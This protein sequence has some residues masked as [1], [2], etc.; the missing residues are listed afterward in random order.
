MFCTTDAE[1]ENALE[2]QRSE[3][4]AWADAAT[5]LVDCIARY[6]ARHPT[7]SIMMEHTCRDRSDKLRLSAPLSPSST[8]PASVRKRFKA[9]N[10]HD[11]LR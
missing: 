8:D 3:A 2:G 4:A 7:S 10:Q 6:G 9:R 11:A 5:E 1:A